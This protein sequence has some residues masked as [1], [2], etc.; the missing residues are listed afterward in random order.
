[1]VNISAE[2]AD[3]NYH[4]VIRFKVHPWKPLGNDK[5]EIKRIEVVTK[6]EYDEEE[7][8]NEITFFRDKK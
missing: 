6:T 2:I 1:M 8:T 5:T 3:V 4:S 7:V